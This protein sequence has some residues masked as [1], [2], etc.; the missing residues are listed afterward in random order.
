LLFFP[1]MF[2]RSIGVAGV[3]VVFVSVSA[4]LTLLPAVLG[5]LGVL[6]D[7]VRLRINLR[8]R[9]S[10]LSQQTRRQPLAFKVRVYGAVAEAL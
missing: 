5:I 3:L 8:Q 7:Q 1:F 10:L 9:P 6:E 4:A 2:I